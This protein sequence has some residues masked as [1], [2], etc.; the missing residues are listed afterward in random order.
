MVEGSDASSAAASTRLCAVVMGLATP[1][2]LALVHGVTDGFHE[3]FVALIVRK[4]GNISR[5][6]TGHQ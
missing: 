3:V 4:F 6:N 2:K 1:I 5:F